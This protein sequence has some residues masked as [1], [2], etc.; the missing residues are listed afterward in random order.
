MLGQ[1]K[2]GY[3][4]RLKQWFENGNPRWDVGYM[5]GKV[6]IEGKPLENYFD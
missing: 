3:V 4:V 2:D 6:G 1:F 5:E